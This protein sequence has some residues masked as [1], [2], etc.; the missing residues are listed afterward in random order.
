MK[1]SLVP[2]SL[3]DTCWDQVEGYLEKACKYTYG[4]YTP[5]D[6]KEMI[7]DD[8]F[9]LWIAYDDKIYGVV[10]TQF[11]TYPRSKHLS[12]SFCGGVNFAKWHDPMIELLK[13]FARDMGCDGI[14]ATGRV[15]WSKLLKKN[16]HKS[17]WVTFELPVEGV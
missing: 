8:Y 2:A 1:V 11:M 10:V 9:H 12:M 15:G 4:R 7:E 6:I 14:E 17:R 13:K 3:I 5:D 16:G